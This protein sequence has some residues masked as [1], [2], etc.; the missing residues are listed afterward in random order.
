MNNI[1]KVFIYVAITHGLIACSQDV[2]HSDEHVES[3]KETTIAVDV[4]L[5]KSVADM[6]NANPSLTPTFA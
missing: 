6:V 2:I 3:T 1:I 5:D 4:T